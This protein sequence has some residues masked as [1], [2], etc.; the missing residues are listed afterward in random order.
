MNFGFFMMPVHHPSKGLPRTIDEDMHTVILADELGFDEVWIGE[1]FTIPWENLPAPDLFIAKALG[2]TKNIKIG[3]GVVL[4]QLHD[5]KMLAHRIAMLD[6]L[7]QGRFYFGVGTGGVPTEFEFFGVEE[8]QRHARAAEV[9]DAVLKIW[10]ADG[11]FDYQGQFHHIT[12]PTP[13]PEVGLGLWLKPYTNPHPPIAVA[14]VSRNSST[15]EWAGENGWIPLTTD[16]LPL[17]HV[18][19]HWEAY[20][21]GA[22]KGG[23]VADR[24]EWRVSLDIHVAETTE[25]AR[26]DV[27]NHGMARTFNEYFFPLFR[28]MGMMDLLKSDDSMPDQDLTVEYLLENRWV[29][30]DPDY[31]LQKIREVYDTVGGFGTLLQ[32][33]QDWDPPEKGWKSM[34]LFMKHIAPELRDLLPP[35]PG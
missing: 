4:L 32:L 14:G 26:N 31:C 25:E 27:L 35:P 30:G 19:S 6:H 33:S 7:A 20:Q 29:V 16:I 23:K 34:E 11:P 13:I 9:V 21:R 17:E 15:I 28:R 10:E 2:L 5:P 22:A 1:H 8:D 18:P 12:S 3:T 24:R